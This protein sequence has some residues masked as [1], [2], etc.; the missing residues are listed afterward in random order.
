MENCPYA[1]RKHGDVSIHCKLVDPPMD[2]CGHQYLCQ[3][4]QRWEATAQINE[5]P[6][7]KKAKTKNK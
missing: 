1:Y 7:R 3:K 4:T 6:L 2:Y 5:C